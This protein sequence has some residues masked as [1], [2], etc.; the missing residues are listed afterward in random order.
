M[1][2]ITNRKF[3]YVNCLLQNKITNT[4][5]LLISCNV[6]MVRNDLESDARKPEKR[7]SLIDP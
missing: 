5:F 4:T 2:L 7:E 3:V 6:L 1:I